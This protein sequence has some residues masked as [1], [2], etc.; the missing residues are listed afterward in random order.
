MAKAGPYPSETTRSPASGARTIWE[1]T[2]AV[3][4]PLFAATNASFFTSAGRTEE[5]AGLKED[6]ADRHAE[7]DR[8]HP[9]RGVVPHRQDDRQDRSEQVRADHHRDP[10]PPVHQRP[11][12]WR[13]QEHRQDLG[14]HNPADAEPGPGQVI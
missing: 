10:G 14:D 2:A 11:G 7:R 4:I 5:A 1:R 12:E 9:D 6:R 3:Q 13:D 8:V